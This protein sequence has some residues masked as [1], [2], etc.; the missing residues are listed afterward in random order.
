LLVGQRFRPA[1]AALEEA[2][3]G[4]TPVEGMED[5]PPGGCP[6]G[7]AALTETSFRP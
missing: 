3:L 2:A 5:A 1:G 7:A 4:D 6:L